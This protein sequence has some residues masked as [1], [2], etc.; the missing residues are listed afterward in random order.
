MDE[1][2]RGE[3]GCAAHLATTEGW[4]REGALC[5]IPTISGLAW[6]SLAR[7]KDHPSGIE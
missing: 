1:I 3:N 6:S 7:T 2:E 5:P 4:G